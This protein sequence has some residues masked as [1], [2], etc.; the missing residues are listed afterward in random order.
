MTLPHHQ[1]DRIHAGERPLRVW[2]EHRGLEA[3]D[4]RRATKISVGRLEQLEAGKGKKMDPAEER[5]LAR[6]LEVD[7][8]CLRP[9]SFA[10]CSALDVDEDKI[11]ASDQDA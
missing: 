10:G 1:S 4:L 2:R 6:A 9:M 5:L 3:T 8:A 11:L 7:R